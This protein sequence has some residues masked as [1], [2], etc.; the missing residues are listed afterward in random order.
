MNFNWWLRNLFKEDNQEDNY[1]NQYLNKID[2]TN[3]ALTR[4]GEMQYWDKFNQYI[5]Q[6]PF[7]TIERSK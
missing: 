7:V 6:Y 2:I 3:I 1:D 5:N 4:I